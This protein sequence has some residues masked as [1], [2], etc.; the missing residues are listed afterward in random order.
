MSKQKKILLNLDA[1]LYDKMDLERTKQHLTVSDFI[2]DAIKAK[3]GAAPAIE[4][5]L[6]DSPPFDPTP[7]TCIR[8]AGH[9]GPCNGF[10][11]NE[12]IPTQDKT[13]AEYWREQILMW[14]GMAASE[15]KT[16]L[17]QSTGGKM[18]PSALFTDL[19]GLAN[20]LAENGRISR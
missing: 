12:C 19:T 8:K 5:S 17:L 16:A 10:P 9:D 2:R 11:R 14:R 4:Q 1:E 13:N 18:P 7:T 15:A 3:I 20:W 6:L